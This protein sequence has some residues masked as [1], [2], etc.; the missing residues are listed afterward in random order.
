MK[1]R[2]EKKQRTRGRTRLRAFLAKSRSSHTRWSG[3]AWCYFRPWE[4]VVARWTEDVTRAL[5]A[6]SGPAAT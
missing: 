1:R 2:T 5:A 3:L 4:G 6:R